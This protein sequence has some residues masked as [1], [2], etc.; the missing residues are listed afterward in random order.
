MARLLFCVRCSMPGRPNTRDEHGWPVILRIW[1]LGY[2]PGDERARIHRAPLPDGRGAEGLREDAAYAD[3]LFL[4]QRGADANRTARDAMT[5]AK[6]LTQ[7]RE[8]FQGK[9]TPPTLQA[10]WDWAKA[11]GLVT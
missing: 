10:L 9:K 3:A 1:Y 7:H 11:Q 5:F 8:Q 4:L 2:S 6:M